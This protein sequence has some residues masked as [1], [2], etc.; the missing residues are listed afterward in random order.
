LVEEDAP[1]FCGRDD[2]IRELVAKVQAHVFVAVVGASGSGKSSLVFAGLLPALRKESQTRTWDVVS[3]RPG[4]W[5]LSALADAFGT[6]PEN[7]GPAEI[8][9]YLEREA[10]FYRTG[11]AHI[12]ARIVDRRLDAAPERPD[13]L[14]IYV[15]QWE[16]LYAMAPATEDKEHL[17]HTSDVDKFIRLLIAAT[18]DERRSRAT[19]VFTV[20]ADFYDRLVQSPL[21]SV[22]L[23]QQQ[24]NIPLMGSGD[25]RSAIETPAKNAGLSFSPPEL[26]DQILNDVG[27]Q[28]G[29]LP[30]LQFAL[31]E[32]WERRKENKLMAEAYTAVGGVIG[33]IE[34][35]AES[36][37]N[38]LTPAQQ[39]AARH[40]FLRLVTPGE[41]QED[42]RAR[43]LIPDD[44]QQRDVIKLFSDPKTRLLVTGFS[45]L[46]GAGGARGNVR[47]TVE[48]A[49]EAL[50]QRWPTLK[51]WV[52]GN[53][54]KLRARAAI[55][56][57]MAEWNEN[58]RVDRFLLDRGV[59]LGRGR[60]LIKDPGDVPI[61]DIRDY[62]ECSIKRDED[63]LAAEREAALADQKR[64]T[65]AERQAKEA[66]EDAARQSEVARAAAEVARRKLRN[67]LIQ[68][69][70]VAVIALVAFAASLYLASLA[71]QR[72]LESQRQ[73]DRANK[74]LAAGI[75]ADLDLRKLGGLYRGSLTSR[76]R[77]ALWKLATADE[78]VR[79]AFI[80]ALSASPEDMART[81]VGFREVS[82]SLG[83]QWPSSAD[84]NK[85][86]TTAIAAIGKTTNSDALGALAEGLKALP[87]RL[88]DAQAQ[89]AI[90][91]LLQQ[92]GKT[93]LAST[94][95]DLANG[96]TALAAKLTDAQA[97]QAIEPLLEQIG[98]TTNPDALRALA[99]GL[100][101]LPVR[102]TDAQAQQAIAPLLQQMGQTTDVGALRALA[103]GLRALP[104][105]LTDAQAQ[106]AIA[107]LLQ[108]IDK[109]TDIYA[110][111]A[112]AEG[113]TALPVKLTDAQAQQAV[114][115][116]LQQIGQDTLG[117]ASKDLTQGLTA[118]AAKLT[119]AQAQQAIAPLLQQIV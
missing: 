118:L 46:Q 114:A 50:I 7:A 55:L 73:L 115:P 1:F 22:L 51:A 71:S 70:S 64:I 8:E 28:E 113:L 91:A 6:A 79:A 78:A 49:H 110:L 16:E 44:P 89:Q 47:P 116:L 39:D 88:T 52:N 43:G 85:L 108:Q 11:D 9:A 14:L 10:E 25:L 77:D 65:A 76:Q 82:R 31:K 24:V 56:R 72:A 35:S 95:N 119:D 33:A 53:R 17:Q 61:D 90:A 54:E 2:A 96:L 87:V 3:L 69:A 68:I 80:S 42:T 101:A 34:K 26:V 20:R 4:K 107:P 23:P 81:A 94:L 75:L 112:L 100:K 63:R 106:Q 117:F 86:L 27:S 32:T 67:R 62:V 111:R 105:R 36:V 98:Q 83:L 74:A 93:T 99:A 84:A 13:R 109:R 40:L 92:I 19:L 97:Q 37:Y 104:V 18:S 21:I 12:L 41:G 102:L 30:L 15:D 48:V 29:R 45:P 103:E 38:R 59:H 66:A 58:G 57:A 60:G 5:P